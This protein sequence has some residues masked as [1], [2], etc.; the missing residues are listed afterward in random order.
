[1]ARTFVKGEFISLRTV[2]VKGR[3][4]LHLAVGQKISKKATDRNKIKRRLR[5]VI[6]KLGIA[7][8]TGTEIFIMPTPEIINKSFVEIN[9][10]IERIFRKAGL[11]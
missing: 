7:P 3:G 10:E 8:K 6:L 9:K 2:W 1:M 4:K 5:A 11:I